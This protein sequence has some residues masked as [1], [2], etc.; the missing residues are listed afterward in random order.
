MANCG[1]STKG[2]SRKRQRHLLV[3]GHVLS[4]G[5]PHES[6]GEI[7]VTPLPWAM[8]ASPKSIVSATR[9][10]KMVLLGRKD[11]LPILVAPNEAA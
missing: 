11:F 1:C 3:G 5:K 10:N 2:A 8:S 7:E 9:T 6:F 4:E